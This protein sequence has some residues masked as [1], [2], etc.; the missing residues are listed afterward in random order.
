MKH[1]CVVGRTLSGKSYLVR[2]IAKGIRRT[3]RPVLSIDTGIDAAAWEKVSNKHF[4][5]W[6]SNNGALQ[7]LDWAKANKNCLI[8]VDEASMTCGR[9][10]DNDMRKEMWWLATQSRHHGHQVMFLMQDHASVEPVIKQNCD[11]LFLFNV[12]LNQAKYWHEQMGAPELLN[13]PQLPEYHFYKCDT[14]LNC[15]QMKI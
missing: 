4:V 6:G 14:R 10:L 8:V 15:Q 5:Q 3:G 9:C 13:A 2:E 11:T 7:L 1:A 12:T